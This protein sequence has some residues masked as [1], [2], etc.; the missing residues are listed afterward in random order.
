MPYSP[1]QPWDKALSYLPGQTCTYNGFPYVWYH[2]TI[3]ST[4][5][6]KP[7]EEEVL[8][9]AVKFEGGTEQRLERGWVMADESQT[10]GG[11]EIT[12]RY[13]NIKTL[14]KTIR[15]IDPKVDP[16][17]EQP[18]L[19]YESGIYPAW[20]QR[21]DNKYNTSSQFYGYGGMSFDYGLVN[22]DANPAVPATNGNPNVSALSF[23]DL[24][25]SGPQF[26]EPSLPFT[27]T[28]SINPTTVEIKVYFTIDETS[29]YAPT[30]INEFERTASYTITVIPEIGE[31]PYEISSTIGSGPFRDGF[32]LKSTSEVKTHTIVF[33]P[34]G[35]S[36]FKVTGL[37][38][39]FD[40]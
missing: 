2:T 4:A 21:A 31:P 36:T 5:N 3:N 29:L 35:S 28:T 24:S 34:G 40:S 19:K 12:A 22:N 6:I 13:G 30:F 33:G 7:N 37:T 9:T 17:N 8:F 10:L 39:R 1:G 38:P 32:S 15:G 14:Q 20:W 11:G 25:T 26:Y 27:E 23:F 18:D 16:L